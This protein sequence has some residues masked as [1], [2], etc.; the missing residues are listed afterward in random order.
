[1]N[2]GPRMAHSRSDDPRLKW[3]SKTSRRKPWLCRGPDRVPKLT[4]CK[5]IEVGAQHDP[6]PFWHDGSEGNLMETF[7]HANIDGYLPWLRANSGGFVVNF[8]WK[9][10]K[11]LVVHRATCR[12]IAK[13]NVNYGRRGDDS[14]KACFSVPVPKV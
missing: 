10:G 9:G 2:L 7:T 4:A 3:G 14:G 13:A 6:P 8:R 12:D 5:T 11:H 1:M